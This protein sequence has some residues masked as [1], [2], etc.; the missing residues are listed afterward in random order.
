MSPSGLIKSYSSTALHCFVQIQC[1]RLNSPV[2]H[3]QVRR[4][5]HFLFFYKFTFKSSVSAGSETDAGSSFSSKTG[6]WIKSTQ[7]V[8]HAGMLQIYT[9]LSANWKVPLKIRPSFSFFIKKKSIHPSSLLSSS[10]V[11][12]QKQF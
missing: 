6:S 5:V 2:L 12:W 9:Q 4:G 11:G 3:K 1:L 7:T 10:F 8:K